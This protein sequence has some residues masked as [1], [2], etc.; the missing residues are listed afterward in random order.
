MTKRIGKAPNALLLNRSIFLYYG[1]NFIKYKIRS[2]FAVAAGQGIA[3]PLLYDGYG[4]A[5]DHLVKDK[6][7]G[8][9]TVEINCE[10]GSILSPEIP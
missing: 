7:R 1:K 8:K 2:Q 3:L 4:V 5:A 6:I 9:G 10:A